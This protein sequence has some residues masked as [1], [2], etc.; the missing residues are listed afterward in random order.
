VPLDVTVIIHGVVV[1]CS[2][3]LITDVF[4]N[5]KNISIRN[6][7]EYFRRFKPTF[8]HI[9]N[10]GSLWHKCELRYFVT[11]NIITSGFCIIFAINVLLIFQYRRLKRWTVYK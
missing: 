8:Q 10:S 6:L 3:F 7:R 9:N 1:L 2:K 4:P 11:I 5:G